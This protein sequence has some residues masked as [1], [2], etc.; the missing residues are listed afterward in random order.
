MRS[1][2]NYLTN[3]NSMNT[4]NSDIFNT[5]RSFYKSTNDKT[6]RVKKL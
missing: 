4:K 3:Q 5:T 2:Y 6:E 1:Q